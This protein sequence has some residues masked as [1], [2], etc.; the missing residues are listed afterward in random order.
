MSAW[1]DVNERRATRMQGGLYGTQ[2]TPEQTANAAQQQQN[3]FSQ[4]SA[5]SADSYARQQRVASIP[6]D[7]PSMPATMQRGR[8]LTPD[9][10]N[11]PTVPTVPTGPTRRPNNGGA[12]RAARETPQMEPRGSVNSIDMKSNLAAMQRAND[13]RGEARRIAQNRADGR[14]DNWVQDFDRSNAAAD[15]QNAAYERR[16]AMENADRARFFNRPG[17]DTSGAVA[18]F[19]K[20]AEMYDS[21]LKGYAKAGADE[22]LEQ[23]RGQFGLDEAN[24]RGQFG[25]QEADTAGNYRLR[26][27]D[28]TNRG[29][30]D[31]ARVAGEY[32]LQERDIAGRTAERVADIG[33]GARTKAME[34][35]GLYDGLAAAETPEQA[36][37]YERLIQ[38]AAEGRPDDYQMGQEPVQEF[39]N[40][41]MVGRP[42]YGQTPNAQ[43]VMPEVNE[44]REYAMGAK[45]LGLPAVPFEQFLGMRQG[46]KQ[47]A[48][49]QQQ[50]AMAFAN[51]GEIPDPNDVSG[52]MVYDSDPNA[53]TDSIPAMIDGTAPAKLDSGEFVI[54]RDVVAFFGTDRLNKMIAQARKGAA[55]TD[56]DEV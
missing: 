17:N 1:G 22:R 51:G 45:S 44:Y 34:L 54:P 32:G 10:S 24:V 3:R 6:M 41:G 53:P 15:K 16:M 47:V 9:D 8:T 19:N 42:M 36:S 27:A 40:G 38:L 48:A 13:M 50:G 2:R 37:V 31:R 46:A 7:S 55:G 5:A 35:K 52:K 33:A 49:G 43:A 4:A 56:S 20:Q 25:L 21:D 26:E 29:A 23:T 11:V 28:M 14:P 18:L 12:L 30:M 39:A